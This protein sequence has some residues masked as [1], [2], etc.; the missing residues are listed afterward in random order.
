MGDPNKQRKKYSTPSHPWQKERIDEE[1]LLTREYGLKNKK[2]IWRMS[3]LLRNFFLQAKK[4]TAVKTEQSKKETIQLL[5]RLKSLGLLSEAATLTDILELTLKDIMERRLQSLVFRKGLAKSMKQARQFI[6]HAHI[7]V[8]GR[9]ITSPGA[10]VLKEHEGSISFAN[11]SSFID[12]M[13]PERQ[14]KEKLPKKPAKKEPAGKNK[15]REH[16]G[17]NNERRKR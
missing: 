4:L 9:K 14:Q 8:N 15:P 3:S 11:S 7:I 12:E 10:L 5:N 6:T 2:E 1:K 13:H 16:K 17:K